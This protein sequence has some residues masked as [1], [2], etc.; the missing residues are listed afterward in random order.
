LPVTK[1]PNHRPASEHDPELREFVGRSK[2]VILG[3]LS[4][5]GQPNASYAP[6]VESNGDFF[7]LISQLAKHTANIL[8]TARCHVMF[9][10]DEKESVNV[11]ARKRLSY[12][13]DVHEMPRQTPESQALIDAMK[14]RFG[15]TIDMLASL[16]DFRLIRL[17]PTTGVWVRGFAQAIP[18]QG[19]PNSDGN[20][21]I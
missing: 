15:P 13:C 7:I 14:E 5:Q 4:S 21:T 12:D 1:H 18:V 10:A 3:T 20:P 11:F 19:F 2:T 16:P 17:H 9:I 8:A 6:F